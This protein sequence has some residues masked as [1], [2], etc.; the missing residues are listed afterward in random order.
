MSNAVNTIQTNF[1]SGELSPLMNGRVDVTKYQ[2]GAAQIEN[3]V[4]KP[5]GPLA[6]RMGTI[7][8]GEVEDSSRYTR[9]I[10]FKFSESQVYIIELGH[11]VLRIWKNKA[12]LLSGGNPI[13]VVSPYPSTATQAVHYTQS[14][15]VVYFTHPSYP[16]YRLLRYSDTNW[17]MEVANFE[18]GPYRVT[19]PTDI[20]NKLWLT[21]IVSTAK[22]TSTVAEFVLGD[23]NS[24]IEFW[25]Q[26]SLM[27]G[28]ITAFIDTKTVTIE[29]YFNTVDSTTIDSTAAISLAWGTPA[30][31]YSNKAIWSQDVENSYIKVLGLYWMLMTTHCPNPITITGPPG[32][33]TFSADV[34]FTTSTVAPL[35]VKA[36]T[37][38]LALTDELI[39]ATLNTTV[40]LFTAVQDI[41]RHFRMALGTKQVWGWVTAITSAKVATVRLGNTVPRDSRSGITYL[42]NAT[43][44]NWKYGAWYTGNYPSSVVFHQGRLVMASSPLEPNRI[45]MS[46][47]DDY[48]SFATTN[49]NSEVLDSSAINIGIASGEVNNVLWLQS[50]PV[51]MV[52]TTGE[53]FQVK[54][55][56]TSDALTPTNLSVV[57]QTSY[58]SA[59]QS[60]PIKIGPSTIFIEQHGQKCRELIYS[61]EIDSFTAAD[62]TIVSE[63]I[64]RNHTAALDLVYQQVPNSLIWLMCVDGKLV[65]LTY[66]KEQEVFAWANHTLGG[67]GF[68]ES[69]AV[70]SNV[71]I[72]Q[73]EL[74]LVVR[75]T[76]NGAT[77]R[78]LEVLA[79]DYYPISETDKNGM[80]Y[81]DCCTVMTG[82]GMEDITGLSHLEGEA[83]SVLADDGNLYTLTVTSGTITLPKNAQKAIIGYPFTSLVKTLPKDLTTPAGTSQGKLKKLVRLDIQL[84][85][86]IGL[87]YG[88]TLTTL[89][90]PKSFREMEFIMGVSTNL[91]TG[92]VQLTDDTGYNKDGQFFLVQ[93]QPYPLTISAVMPILKVNE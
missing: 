55:S 92:F 12:L 56:G 31:V 84:L 27:L 67:N 53:E 40:D 20:D 10:P 6:R 65:S 16:P 28:K 30:Y 66:E 75:R 91:F 69:V 29:P 14:A 85:N 18:D 89:S 42:D 61:F 93:D 50:G 35:S 57:A 23:V 86:S 77:K 81:L 33:N 68:V 78:Y 15:D 46:Y 72:H 34:M 58:G 62:V 4:V 71:A 70:L 26:G 64:L 2:N 17:V 90:V 88:R 51:L 5:Q 63:H 80:V 59:S 54:P 19:K 24:L 52:G 3:F 41:G 37:G 83:V 60:R 74:Y 82:E 87:K 79:P 13:E 7:Y 36:T 49:L 39:T 45:W 38:L 8:L 43:T 21:N 11:N 25:Y 48:T 76:I 32:T 22:I 44:N 47:A 9:I 73:D 1:S